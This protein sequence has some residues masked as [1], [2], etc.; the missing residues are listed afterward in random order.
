MRVG[1]ETANFLISFCHLFI[2]RFGC[3]CVQHRAEFNEEYT[4]L[5]RRLASLSIRCAENYS[6]EKL[7]HMKLIE[8]GGSDKLNTQVHL[9]RTVFQHTM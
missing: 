9:F 5:H 1:V 3:V 2:Y 4:R 7:A 6:H 8:V